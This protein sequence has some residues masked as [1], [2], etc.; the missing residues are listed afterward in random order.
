MGQTSMTSN[1]QRG[2]NWERKL[3]TNIDDTAS[4]IKDQKNT[5]LEITEEVMGPACGPPKGTMG[6][7]T[8]GNTPDANRRLILRL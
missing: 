3:F 1:Y 8:R 6:S 2:S 5:I 7:P 4:P